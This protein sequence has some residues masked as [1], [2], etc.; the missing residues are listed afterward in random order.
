MGINE[1]VAH[2]DWSTAPEPVRARV[3]DLVTDTVAVAALG[4]T[5]PEIRRLVQALRTES[6]T[7]RGA[8]VIGSTVAWTPSTAAFLHGSAVA[9]DQ[10]QDGHREARGHPASHVVPAALA[11]S[12]SEGSS[13]PEFLSSVLAGYETGTRFGRAMGGTPAGVHDIGTWGTVAVAATTTR[14]LSPHDAH[15]AERALDLG[16]SAVLLTDAATIFDGHDAGHAFLGASIQLGMSLGRAAVAG[17][18]G[19]SRSRSRHFARVASSHWAELE[20][21]TA[22]RGWAEF[23]VLKGYIKL[24]PTCAHLH[25][26]NDAVQDS[27]EDVLSHGD[28][29]TSIRS[30]SVRTYSHAA[31]FNAIADSEL[32]ARFS[33]PTSVAVALATGSLDHH[34]FTDAVVLSPRVRELARLVRVIHDPALDEGYPHGRPAQVTIEHTDGTVVA[35]ESWRPRGDADPERSRPATRAKAMALLEVLYGDRAADVAALIDSI[36]D[37][38]DMSQFGSRIRGLTAQEPA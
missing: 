14:L 17:L 38:S 1:A 27:L 37:L 30:I 9:A 18:V 7:A 20:L 34:S 3:L 16:T 31:Q 25:G 12:E 19:D 4:M 2:T 22:A 8:S 5:R 26:V 13:G 33:I 21:T 24:H 28:P 29:A 32:G 35:S 15:A 11:L 36:P 6:T 10:L 23:E